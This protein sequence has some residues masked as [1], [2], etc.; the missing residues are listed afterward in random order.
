MTS[1]AVPS[2]RASLLGLAAT[3]L[4]ASSGLAACALG[5]D[6]FAPGSRADGGAGDSGAGDTGGGSGHDAADAGQPPDAGPTP[7][8]CAGAADCRTHASAC[9]TACGQA[10]QQCQGACHNQQCQNGE[11]PGAC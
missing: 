9:G 11:C 4:A 6:R 10:S 1:R 3:V 8:A 7:D 5:F 2:R